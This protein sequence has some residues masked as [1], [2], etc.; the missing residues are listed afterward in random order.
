MMRR[1]VNSSLRFRVA[2]AAAAVGVM[3][4]GLT[5]LGHAPVDIYPEFAPPYIEV[6]TEALG[7]SSNEVEQ[8]ITVP[9]EADLLNGVAWVKDIRSESVPGLSSIT[10][11]FE[12]GTSLFRARQAVQ[13]R[14]AQA[15]AIPNVSKPP[16]ML[17][18][19][20]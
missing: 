4:F 6:Q 10:L 5:Q 18:P 12:P 13:E 3:F 20:S 16:P 11:V 9:L 19:G 2:V 1:I 17:Q 14:L 7:L 8:M 15:F